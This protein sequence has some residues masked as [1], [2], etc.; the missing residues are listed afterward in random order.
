MVKRY[1]Y[2]WDYITTDHKGFNLVK[3][4]RTDGKSIDYTDHAA[5][6]RSV[7]EVCRA[8]EILGQA[9]PECNH[10][11]EYLEARELARLVLD[12]HAHYLAEWE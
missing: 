6:M 5:E 1:D 4:D 9:N 11:G 3:F 2:T 7:V 10:A 8:I 12:K